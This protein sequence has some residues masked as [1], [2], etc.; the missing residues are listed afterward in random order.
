MFRAGRVGRGVEAAARSELQGS[1]FGHSPFQVD[2]GLTARKIRVTRTV[3]VAEE[4]DGERQE[5]RE[6]KCDYQP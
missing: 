6:A 2:Q 3:R 1:R 4:V 5:K